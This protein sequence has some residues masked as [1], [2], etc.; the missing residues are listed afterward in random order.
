MPRPVAPP[1]K[2]APGAPGYR[3]MPV[4]PVSVPAGRQDQSATA[5]APSLMTTPRGPPKAMP[6]M[7]ELQAEAKA[8]SLSSKPG[9]SSR[10]LRPQHPQAGNRA[11]RIECR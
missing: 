10:Q 6:L 11:D 7:A 8:R 5:K 9:S 4:P 3:F 1:A 2:P